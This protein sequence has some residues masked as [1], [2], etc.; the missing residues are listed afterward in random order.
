MDYQEN[1]NP[2]EFVK[3]AKI[4]TSK[5]QYTA[6]VDHL[7]PHLFG[8]GFLSNHADA[9]IAYAEALFLG[10]APH[11]AARHLLPLI[12]ENNILFGN[13]DAVFVFENACADAYDEPHRR[14]TKKSQHALM[15]PTP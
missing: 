11:W 4:L 13:E 3:T 2:D 10:G 5:R 8:E 7:E 1:E 12:Q 15:C 6:A 9:H 14:R